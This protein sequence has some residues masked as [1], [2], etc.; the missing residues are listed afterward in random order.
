MS[1]LLFSDFLYRVFYCRQKSAV[2]LLINNKFQ[3][4]ICPKPFGSPRRVSDHPGIPGRDGVHFCVA[5][6][7]SGGTKWTSQESRMG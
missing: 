4:I 5:A 3:E 2:V 6:C 7:L 1:V